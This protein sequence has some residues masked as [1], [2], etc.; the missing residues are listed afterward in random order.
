M[1]EEAK[2]E[3]QPRGRTEIIIII[4]GQ[5]Q[6]MMGEKLKHIKINTMTYGTETARGR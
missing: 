4:T 5:A 6:S 3:Q 2:N 1:R